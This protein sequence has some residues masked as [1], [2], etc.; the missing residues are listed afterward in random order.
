ML[1]SKRS[2]AI[3][4]IA[5]VCSAQALT[6]IG[7]FTFSALLPTFFADWG[8]SHT[9]AGW[10]SGIIFLAYALSVPFILPLTDRID[11]RRVYICFVSLTCLSHLGM[12][13]V[14]DGFW[15]GMMFRILA[16]IGWGGTYMVGLKALA[17]LIEGPMQSRAVAFHAGSIGVGGSLSFLIAGWTALHFSWHIAFMMAKSFRVF[18]LC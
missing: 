12:A 6:Q 16:G 1:P 9:E 3:I 17:D 2:T 11:P 7:S 5:A 10:L 18:I 14:A 15:T 8:I 13:F 4:L